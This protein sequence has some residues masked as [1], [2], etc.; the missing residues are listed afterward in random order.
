MTVITSRFVCSDS[1][2]QSLVLP[3]SSS[4]SA[5]VSE[6]R[7]APVDGR[8]RLL[9]IEGDLCCCEDLVGA[10]DCEGF[11]VEIATTAEEGLRMF[12]E[13]P[14][15]LVLLGMSLPDRSGIDTCRR[16][17]ELNDIP[18]VFVDHRSV[19]SEV[20]LGLEAGAED[21]VTRP[22]R[23]QEMVARIRAVLRRRL[24]SECRSLD[25]SKLPTPSVDETVTV[26]PIELSLQSRRLVVGGHPVHC[27]PKEF[28]LL[29]ALASPPE[30]LRTREE[31]IDQVWPHARLTGT[32]TVDKHVRTLRAKIEIDPTKPRHL[33]TVHGLGF[34]LQR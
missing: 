29:I 24:P 7:V 21:Y 2:E 16:L 1:P 4:R 3:G 22:C 13:S 10:L 18:I 30:I 20:V 17:L 34:R 28:D 25:Q 26:G 11:N 14:P 6:V 8:H 23:T 5:V 32:R 27:A 31:L 33:I 9:V 12:S 15:E 19:E